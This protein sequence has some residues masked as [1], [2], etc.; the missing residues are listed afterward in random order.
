[1]KPENRNPLDPMTTALHS[2]VDDAGAG[3]AVTPL[4]QSSA[5]RADS[6]YFYTR[7]DNPNCREFEQM[8]AIL[9]GAQRALSVTT[10]MA[11]IHLAASLLRPGDALVV[12]RYI[13][14][15]S[16]RY[17]TRL[18]DRRGIRL[19]MLDL[20]S[21]EGVDG[22]PGDAAM[23]LFETPTNPLLK[24]VNIS[25]VAARAKSLN[26]SVIVVVDNTWATSLYQK[27]LRHG[28]DISLHSATKFFSGHSD[29]MGGIILT[30]D[31]QIEAAL[32]AERFYTGAILDPHSAWLL[33]RS[34]RTFQVRMRQHEKTTAILAEFLKGL[35][36]V[37]TV[38]L[39]AVDGCQLTGYGGILFLDLREDLVKRYGEFARNLRLFD[40]GTGM[41][42][43]T[44]MVAQ[45]FTGSH[46]SLSDDEKRQM[47]LGKSLVRLCFGMED[48][49]D[50]QVDLAQAFER[51]ESMA[52]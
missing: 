50:L 37:R 10:G 45:P 18:A 34:M 42:C 27:P 44:S 4:Y 26:P 14:G 2:R 7:K 25:A 9:E 11:A 19:T 24:T 3:P 31:P 47:G 23:V 41:A 35:P 13:Y 40:T 8:I 52:S 29:V 1:M 22:I 16:Y 38:Y 48:P 15:C 36:Q 51:M 32:R 49:D 6:P 39:P 20:T 21:P 46:A 43:V 12:N 28:A 17:C 30:D 5:F 33:C